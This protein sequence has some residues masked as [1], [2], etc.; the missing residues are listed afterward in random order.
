M[1]S[2]TAITS[3]E[4]AMAI[5]NAASRLTFPSLAPTTVMTGNVNQMVI[6]LVD[7][8]SGRGTAEARGRLVKMLPA[9]AAFAVGAL[10]GA[11]GYVAVGFLCLVAPIAA[12]A[13][14][15]MVRP[16]G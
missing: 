12:T 7:L 3:P 13:L 10:A 6:D 15:L 8:A 4:T 1:K 16:R 14:V 5:Q 11:L 9:V 2:K